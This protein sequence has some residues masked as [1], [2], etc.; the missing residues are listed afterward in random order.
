MNVADG[1]RPPLQMNIMAK[2]IYFDANL[3]GKAF[4]VLKEHED[5]TLDIGTGKT[6]VVRKCALT[7]N[8]K[9][10]FAMRCAEPVKA[11]ETQSPESNV[12]SPKSEDKKAE[13]KGRASEAK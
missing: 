4:D 9:H 8:P 11:G 2:V 6:V 5:G 13:A 7:D 10:G 3:K 12:Q 1:T